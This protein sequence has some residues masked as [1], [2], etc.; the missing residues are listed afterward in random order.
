MILMQRL[1]TS[2]TQAIASTLA[3]RLDVLRDQQTTDSPR[4]EGE[5]PGVRADS[6]ALNSASGAWIVLAKNTPSR[7][8]TCSWPTALNCA[9]RKS[10][11]R[12]WRSFS[13][14]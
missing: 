3:R 12:N 10:W 14:P 11:K 9:F 6:E 13:S 5:G 7:R 2:S 4:P 8:L 1:V